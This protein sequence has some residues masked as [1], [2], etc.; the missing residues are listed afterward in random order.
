MPV[1]Q[2][3]GNGMAPDGQ[4]P[5]RIPFE[6]EDAV[7]APIPKRQLSLR[8]KISMAVA[9]SILIA[10]GIFALVT[11]SGGDAVDLNAAKQAYGSARETYKSDRDYAKAEEK[12]LAVRKDFGQTIYSDPS[13]VYIHMCRTQLAITARDWGRA[14][15]EQDSA[16]DLR[17]VIQKRSKSGTKLY[18]WTVKVKD[19]IRDL[20]S[21]RIDRKAFCEEMENAQRLFDN[22][23]YAKA[24]EGL[25]DKYNDPGRLQ[26]DQ[27]KE[28]E[29]F[30]KK[31]VRK[32]SNDECDVLMNEARKVDQSDI[33]AA[34]AAWEKAS[35][36]LQRLK[37]QI[38]GAR[39]EK[40][41]SEVKKSRTK[42]AKDKG[43][44]DLLS[45][46]DNARQSGDPDRLL[47][48]LRNAMVKSGVP[49]KLVERWGTEIKE[50]REKKDFAEIT[51]LLSSGDEQG[52]IDALGPFIAKYPENRKAKNLKA[53]L[54]KKLAQTQAR[55]NAF[56]LFDR[57]RWAEA[58]VELKK[59]RIQDR[60]DRVI[61]EKLNHCKYMLKLVEF[62]GA[63]TAGDYAKAEAAGEQLRVL[64]PD[65]WDSVIAPKL[66]DMRARRKVADTLRK[67][68]AALDNGQYSEARRVLKDL[69]ETNPEAK[70]I[71]RKSRYRESLSKGNAARKDNDL[72]TALAMYKIAKNYAKDPSEHKEIDALI[73][74]ASGS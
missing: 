56:Q 6:T 73:E 53:G 10:G 17:L 21:L 72:V 70:E 25:E 19:T 32:V 54:E 51:G 30:R 49:P 24:I 36:G 66:A 8:A 12:F 27:Q 55:K 40:L 2:P 22:G 64:K 34:L 60:G 16:S 42:L 67:G 14:Q 39:W 9:A 15:K 3:I 29:A 69:K 1:A 57:A 48:A 18:K 59:L 38:E 47:R 28:L 5:E 61:K 4:S 23:K 71:I 65:A 52:A 33:G 43:L 7:T 68:K 45:I 35:D 50:I 41:N 20:E 46:V 26:D 31:V 74:A 63:V 44:I 62:D 37:S 58:L 11:R 13:Q